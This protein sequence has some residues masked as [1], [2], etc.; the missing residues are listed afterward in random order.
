MILILIS[1]LDLTVI[2]GETGSGKSIILE[3]ISSLINGKFSKSSIKHGASRSVVE[4]E[5]DER[6]TEKFTTK[7]VGQNHT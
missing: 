3:A 6:S 7:Q 5:F 2:T 1:I 4:L